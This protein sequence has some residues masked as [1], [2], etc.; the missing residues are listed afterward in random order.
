MRNGGLLLK[1]SQDVSWLNHQRNSSQWKFWP[2]PTSRTCDT[3]FSF[4]LSLSVPGTSQQPTH[5][6]RLDTLAWQFPACGC[7][8]L[9]PPFLYSPSPL[10]P[11]QIAVAERIDSRHHLS[12]SSV[13]CYVKQI[14]FLYVKSWSS[15]AFKS[16]VS[17]TL[18]VYICDQ[19]DLFMYKER[20]TGGF[21]QD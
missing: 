4:L 1:K 10:Q 2:L 7:F 19:N 18:I 16:T 14:V 17:I 5:H 8:A 11:P 6:Q 9:D 21:L 20:Q 15:Y 3:F 13:S 12:W